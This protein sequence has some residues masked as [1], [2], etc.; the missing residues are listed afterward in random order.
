MLKDAARNC[1]GPLLFWVIEMKEFRT[2]EDI[3]SIVKRFENATIARDD[4]GHP[5]HLVVALHYIATIG[6][7]EAA[8]AKMRAGIFNLLRNGFGIDLTKEMPYHETL[9]VFWMNAVE[10]YY[11]SR[12]ADPLV[13]IA[14]EIVAIFD[15]DHP[16]RSY[17]RERLFSDD[18]RSRY[19]L[20]D[21]ILP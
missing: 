9:T 16:L 14:N 21:I 4:W 13:D 15:K 7:I 3:L 1:S 18:A 12:N 11:M 17:S 5:E 8:T 20:P 2:E 6:D 10:Q 19:I